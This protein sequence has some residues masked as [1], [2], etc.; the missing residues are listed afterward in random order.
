M[1]KIAGPLLIFL[2][3]LVV[4]GAIG[5]V[6]EGRVAHKVLALWDGTAVMEMAVNARDIRLGQTT[7]MLARLD[8]ALPR[9]AMDYNRLF[10]SSEMYN[11][12]MWSVQRY[13]EDCPEA[14]APADLKAILA[15]LPSRPR[16]KCESEQPVSTQP[17]LA[18]QRVDK[19]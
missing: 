14:K 10:K 1:K 13:Y 11:G 8:S 3:G 15:E 5:Y 6:Y 7:R 2:A 9:A 12:V 19:Q 16:T 17:A 4:G 18:P